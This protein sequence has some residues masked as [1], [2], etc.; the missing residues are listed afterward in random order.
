[1]V[2]DGINKSFSQSCQFTGMWK[3][4]D[5]CGDTVCAFYANVPGQLRHQ[6]LL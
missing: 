6:R 4:S 2:I 3:C 1:V 5:S